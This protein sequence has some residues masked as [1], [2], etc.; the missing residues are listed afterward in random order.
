MTDSKL[1]DSSAWLSYFYAENTRIRDVMESDDMLLTSSLSL[2]EV[3]LKL[4]KD[5]KEQSLIQKSLEIIK[6]R[7]LVIPM[8]TKIGEKAAE[9]SIALRLSAIDSLIYTTS[10][11]NNATLVTLDND[12]RGLKDVLSL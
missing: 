3:K 9:I 6:K 2:F 7:S 11:T 5:K 8:D 12:F 1:I 10:L 4:L